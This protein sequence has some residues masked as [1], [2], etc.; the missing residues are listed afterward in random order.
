MVII[1]IIIGVVITLLLAGCSTYRDK[2]GTIEVN[3][4]VE[5]VWIEKPVQKVE[6][7]IVKNF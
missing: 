2:P 3:T 4:S 7:K 1:Q 5:D 6:I